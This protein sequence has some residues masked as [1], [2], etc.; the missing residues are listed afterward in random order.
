MYHKPIFTPDRQEMLQILKTRIRPLDQIQM[1]S[2]H[3]ACGRVLGADVKAR[4]DVPNVPSAGCDG[5][6][7]RFNDIA[8][9]IP[10]TTEWTEGIEYAFCN[11]GCQIPA[12]F[13]T[14]IP[15]EAVAFDDSGELS[16]LTAPKSLGWRV[17]PVGA[18]IK[19]DETLLYADEIVTPE[20]IG[21]LLSAGVTDI[22]VYR[23]PRVAF[24]P[25]GI[26][27]VAPGMDPVPPG[28]TTESNG[29]M[30]AAYIER[31]GGEATI[32]P[33][34]TDDPVALKKALS[35]A[36]AA[37]D[38][39]LIC[40][41]SGKG[42][43]DY[44]IDVLTEKG[45]MIVQELG[46]GPGKHCA[47]YL[48]DGKPVMGLPGPPGGTALTTELYVRAAMC[49]LLRQPLPMP[50]TL[51]AKLT[52]PIS[53][54]S[55]DFIIRLKAFYRDGMV[56]AEPVPLTGQTRAQAYH[57]TNARLYLKRGTHL[58]A[59]EVVTLE[60]TKFLDCSK[61]EKS[62]DAGKPSVGKICWAGKGKA[63][64]RTRWDRD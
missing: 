14:V 31:W 32:F 1:V 56:Y 64:A 62:K 28:K 53:E 17:I 4:Y 18:Q 6:A 11:T 15:I 25:T 8:S 58:E 51:A 57:G 10:D 40:A 42:T 3:L 2:T 12:A 24:L 30:T 16:L 9:G 33:I 34:V 13:D 20:A 63:G 37:F 60:L 46:H 45:E 35:E 21:V 38:L 43:H 26:E 50:Q 5:I 61:G 27:L 22:P 52:R 36:L 7:V 47:L 44:T 29:A 19:K 54:M 39:V 41:G 48:V 23:K 55:M 49:R 59:G